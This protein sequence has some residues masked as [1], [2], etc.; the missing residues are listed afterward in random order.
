MLVECVVYLAVFVILLAVAIGTFYFCWDASHGLMQN[1]SDI[2]AALHAGERWRADVRSASGKIS[3]ETTA[4]GEVV[5]IPEG[6][7]EIVYSFDAGEVR[8]QAA[9]NGAA[10]LLLPKVKSSEMK[11]DL[12]GDVTAWKWELELVQHSGGSRLPLLFTFEA[13]QKTL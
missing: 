13:A 3:I 7:E 9:S 12:R 1:T 10:Q 2:S 11:I 6:K 5:K 8:R 4:S